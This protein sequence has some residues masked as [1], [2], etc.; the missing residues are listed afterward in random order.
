MIDRITARGLAEKEINKLYRHVRDDEIII[1]DD[2]T[3]EKEFGWVFFYTSRKFLETGN[4]LH[5]LVGNAPI[6]VDKNGTLHMTGTS[7]PIEEYIREFEAKRK[8]NL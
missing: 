8:I 7:K 2:E 6:I 5:A 4:V 3:I 1:L